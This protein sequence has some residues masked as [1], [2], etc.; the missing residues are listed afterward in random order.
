MHKYIACLFL[1]TLA[2]NKT[3]AQEISTTPT[4]DSSFAVKEVINNMFVAMKNCDTVLLKT[5]F[6][7]SAVLQTVVTKNGVVTVKDE[8]LNDF[9]NSISKQPAGSL[10][11]RIKFDAVKVNK[12]LAIAWT[13]YQFYYKGKY[14]HEGVNSFQLVKFSEG[15]KI[16]YLIDTRYR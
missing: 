12:E 10:D 14:S 7:S 16:Q 11:E 13:P 2:L 4:N 15:W 3:N 5:C 6:S 8:L 9:I 1:F